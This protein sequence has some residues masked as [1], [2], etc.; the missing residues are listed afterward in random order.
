VLELQVDPEAITPRQT[1]AEIRAAAL[2]D[3]G[4]PEGR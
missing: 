3:A 2:L 4:A 1:I